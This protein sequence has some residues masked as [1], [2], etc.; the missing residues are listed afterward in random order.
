M[1]SHLNKPP[2]PWG[3]VTNIHCGNTFLFDFDSLVQ[4]KPE[5][6][7]FFVTKAGFAIKKHAG[8]VVT[9]IAVAN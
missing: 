7:P 5:P 6:K 9:G 2:I 3:I 4:R 8:A 1:H